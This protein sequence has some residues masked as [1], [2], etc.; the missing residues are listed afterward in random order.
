MASARMAALVAVALLLLGCISNTYVQKVEKSGDAEMSFSMNLTKLVGI[1]ALGGSFGNVSNAVN[2][3]ADLEKKMQEFC[4]NRSKTDVSTRCGYAY[5]TLVFSRR[6]SL[7]EG[8][9]KFSAENL[10]G[11]DFRGKRY[12]FTLERL[13][14]IT[15]PL[16]KEM[17]GKSVSGQGISIST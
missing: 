16:A 9:Y 3:T 6:F 12:T 5:N 2:N 10:S 14:N 15:A 13:P 7:A 17:A 1:A 8:A 4:E 11:Q